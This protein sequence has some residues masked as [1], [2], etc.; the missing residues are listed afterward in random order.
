ML[1]N[2][3]SSKLPV[4]AFQKE[5]HDVCGAFSVEPAKGNEMVKGTVFLENRAG[6]EIAHI[7][8]DL[9]TIRR[10]E[11]D[12]KQDSGENFFLIVQE[13]GRAMMMQGDSVNLMQPGDM[14][15]IDSA[16]PSEFAFF[17]SYGRQVSVHLPREE[18]FQRFGN[19]LKGGCFLS[20]RDYLTIAM[21]AVLAKAF[22]KHED[23]AQ[24]AHLREAMLGLVGA[25]M[26]ERDGISGSGELEVDANGAK[27]L[28]NGIAYID[29]LF[30]EGDLTIQAMACS[31]STSTRQLQRV[32]GLIGTTPSDYLLQ[33][34]LEHACKLLV[35]R[36]RGQN[37]ERVSAI[38]Y[39]SGFNDVSYFNRQFRR[40]FQC[41][42]G[43]FDA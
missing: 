2:I 41:T 26:C 7:A 21:N 5:L 31:L 18:M 3:E 8:K 15:L 13:E 23:S 25:W 24:L 33:K 12:I 16:R 40:H 17:G 14:I 28:Q 6:L 42:P 43:Q 37:Q 9:Q 34:R 22:G 19:R 11:R 30:K 38:A 29:R 36:R 4:D 39:A 32:F 1:T 27:L 20:R 35:A 10:T